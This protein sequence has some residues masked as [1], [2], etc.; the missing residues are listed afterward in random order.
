MC[1]GLMFFIRCTTSD[2]S[3]SDETDATPSRDHVSSTGSGPVTLVLNVNS[4]RMKIVSY[5]VNADAAEGYTQPVRRADASS[6]ENLQNDK[7]N[8]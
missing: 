5:H 7:K 3:E 2:A 6:S 8:V 4:P 1:V